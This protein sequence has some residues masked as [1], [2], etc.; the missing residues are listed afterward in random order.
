[1][2]ELNFISINTTQNVDIKEGES[3]TFRALSKDDF[4]QHIESHLT[5]SKTDGNLKNENDSQSK[6]TPQVDEKHVAKEH[7]TT[8]IQSESDHD[9]HNTDESNSEHNLASETQKVAAIGNESEITSNKIT[10]DTD[11][12]SVT[13]SELLM[14][15]LSKVDKTLV[16]K[17]TDYNTSDERNI[18]TVNLKDDVLSSK[19][20]LP[21]TQ[22]QKLDSSTLKQQYN[23]T[24]SASSSKL[25]DLNTDIS[26]VAKAITSSAV[27]IPGAEYSFDPD[28][29]I[30]LTKESINEINKNN[31]DK[32]LLVKSIIDKPSSSIPTSVIEKESD[33]V[34]LD[35]VDSVSVK[36]SG[37]PKNKGEQFVSNTNDI[38]LPSQKVITSTTE[39]TENVSDSRKSLDV[40]INNSGAVLPQTE[41]I[42]QHTTA[43]KNNNVNYDA[44]FQ[45]VKAQSTDKAKENSQYLN[46]KHVL[47][48]EGINSASNSDKLSLEKDKL[49]LAANEKPFVA[50]SVTAEQI[51]KQ[52]PNTQ[53]PVS[54][55][56]AAKNSNSQAMYTQST[57][58]NIDFLADESST[59][60]T[61]TRLNAKA[62]VEFSNQNGKL[63]SG[64]NKGV[65]INDMAKTLEQ[66]TSVFSYNVNASNN[67]N[68]AIQEAYDR[69]DHQTLEMVTPT[70]SSDVSQSQ[71]TN[72]QLHQETIAIFRKDFSDAVKDKV[73]LMISQ[74]LQQFDISLDPPELGNMQVRVNLQGEQASV[75]F[76][77]QNQQAKEALD[78][79]MHK[80]KEMLAEQG[81]DVGDANV[82]Q[83]SQHSDSH[84][85]DIDE[86]RH[87]FSNTEQASD[88]ITHNISVKRADSSTQVVDYY[89]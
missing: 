12:R 32:Q 25:S 31:D 61:E 26:E 67:T 9:T 36:L 27:E 75:N 57:D 7:Q 69:I 78:Q 6:H 47:S 24:I 89:A 11:S 58:I 41:S 16:A 40:A 5:K 18:N 64:D 3:T 76:I 23:N 81:V 88:V 35:E 65:G 52:Q 51:K 77:V 38:E 39:Q 56:L 4:S 50:Q 10:A 74:K 83:Q 49:T 37:L 79:N 63:V 84:E 2:Q 17:A 1:M 42:Q 46:A 30:N 54:Q 55:A 21:P 87:R 13:E 62:F 80:L 82:D 29:S 33:K 22:D 8:D 86:P 43:I 71:K 70:S 85:S 34:A 20:G 48:D 45:A 73:M 60:E 28:K 19:N 68:Q 53:Q 59:N 72:I 15:F 14:S 44:D 66:T